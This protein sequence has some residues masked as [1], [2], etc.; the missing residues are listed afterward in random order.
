MELIKIGNF[1]W[2]SSRW[3]DSHSV[4]DRIYLIQ[5]DDVID[6]DF[7]W[8]ELISLS[9]YGT[10]KNRFNGL[11]FKLLDKFLQRPFL[12]YIIIFVI[13]IINL[14][15]LIKIGKIETLNVYSSY[16]DYDRSDHLTVILFPFL[17]N[18]K[19]VRAI[20][21]SR[22]DF[23]Y[24]ELFCLSHCNTII[25]NSIHNLDF[26]KYK[27]K[28]DFSKKKILF[29]L[30]EDWRS[31]VFSEKIK[32]PE[33]FS[34][35]TKS[36]HFV[37]LSGRV[38]SELGN[39]RSGAR[40]YYI[41]L[42]KEIIK[43]GQRV[44]LYTGEVVLTSTGIDLYN[45]L[46]RTSGGLFSVKGLL[47][48]K[49]NP[50]AAYNT[51][52]KYDFGILHNFESDQKVSYFDKFNIPNRFYEYQISGVL[53]IVKKGDSFVVEETILKNNCGIVYEELG[54][55]SNCDVT[56]YKM[57]NPSFKDYCFK[58]KEIYNTDI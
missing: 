57:Y 48:F 41:K 52:S 42:I 29:D 11:L 14:N 50:M 3:E 28:I 25:L 36:K 40:Q 16:N 45:E 10:F 20:K 56:K 47:D 58:L 17:R 54:D 15:T 43:L 46:E 33:K 4:F 19:I 7:S 35:K 23:R 39:V 49:N 13:R 18:K 9:K 26:F 37:I 38:F 51:L 21:E 2:P 5:R 8:V 44:D 55:L 53:P 6:H 24:P 22:P 31:F 1:D 34:V 27:Y 12:Y 32:F 30:D